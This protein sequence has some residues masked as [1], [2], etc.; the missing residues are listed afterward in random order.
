VKIKGKGKKAEN[1]LPLQSAWLITTMPRFGGATPAKQYVPM[2][3][4]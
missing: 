3:K 1:S 4:F 2:K